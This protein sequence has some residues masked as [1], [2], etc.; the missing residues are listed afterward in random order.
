MNR[1]E[2]WQ[3]VSRRIDRF[4][5]RLFHKG[6]LFLD[7]TLLDRLSE[8]SNLFS[9]RVQGEKKLRKILLF[10]KESRYLSFFSSSYLEREEKDFSIQT[11]TRVLWSLGILLFIGLS[12]S[13]IQTAVQARRNSLSFVSSYDLDPQI[14]QISVQ[15]DRSY[16]DIRRVTLLEMSSDAW[17]QKRA[18]LRR[19]NSLQENEKLFR[20]T[21]DSTL[22]KNII[23]RSYLQDG[24]IARIRSYNKRGNLIQ[25]D[26]YSYDDKN[27]LVYT[28]S[29]FIK[30]EKNPA[31]IT[32]VSLR[33]EGTL[34]SLSRKKIEPKKEKKATPET[35]QKTETELAGNLNP[36]TPETKISDTTSDTET[37][38]IAESQESTDG[39]ELAVA[40]DEGD[41]TPSPLDS[42]KDPEEVVLAQNKNSEKTQKEN[43]QEGDELANQRDLEEGKNPSEKPEKNSDS[44]EPEEKKKEISPD[45]LPVIRDPNLQI[46]WGT[47]QDH[48]L[49]QIVKR[50]RIE[51]LTE[52]DSRGLI[53]LETLYEEGIIRKKVEKV[54][55]EVG[56]LTR[57]I[58]S[59]ESGQSEDYEYQG[60]LL[61][62]ISYLE[63]GFLYKIREF[64]YNEL[65]QAVSVVAIDTFSG[66]EEEW[67][68]RYDADDVPLYESYAKN[69]RLELEVFY[70][71]DGKKRQE[72]VYKEGIAIF[73]ISYNRLDWESELTLLVKNK[74]YDYRE[75]L[76]AF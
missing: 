1:F 2:N 68:Y 66:D 6:R 7:R 8:E 57:E 60:D 69:Q 39:S 45:F 14:D 73:E 44:A 58:R 76:D 11:K 3:T 30:E 26:T 25:T 34:R 59:F 27:P 74:V 24:R 70:Y 63:Y 46:Y 23:N 54:Y 38:K 50:A 9:Q 61:T 67:K 48:P 17:F 72:I 43:T 4:I 49:Y 13:L 51:E 75:L 20:L 29:T 36:E 31:E 52:Y 40:S 28:I 62:R 32:T 41:S 16:R 65:D 42:K 55:D 12:I 18:L 5:R 21:P 35:K 19:K 56:K 37:Q 22:S 33:K 64:E 71:P 47:N 53:R 15:S 10:I